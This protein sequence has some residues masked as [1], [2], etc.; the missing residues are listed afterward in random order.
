M[1]FQRYS[2]IENACHQKLLNCISLHGFSNETYVVQEK[3][4]G[5]NFSFWFDGTKFRQ[6]KRSSFVD[7]SFFDCAQIV[8]E[9][10]PKIRKAFEV[11]NLS[12]GDVLVIYGEM[13]GGYYNH[14]DVP[15]KSKAVQKGISYRPDK[16][17]YAFDLV[18][19]GRIMSVDVANSLFEICGIDHAVTL[20]EG[21][22][23]ECLEYPNEFVPAIPGRLGLPSIEG[24][25][26]E[27]VVIR[28]KIPLFLPSGDRVILKNKNSK[29]SE[30]NPKRI[31]K[32]GSVQ[33]CNPADIGEELRETFEEAQD[34]IT[35]NRLRNALSKIEVKDHKSFGPLLQEVYTDIIEELKKGDNF[36]NLTFEDQGLIAKLIKTEIS[37]F[38][39][40]RFVNILDGGF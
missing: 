20:F 27:G 36:E 11:L 18:V 13:Y 8:F 32:A 7:D 6:A 9:N 37:A 34:M 38:I 25:I 17:F 2:S 30:N 29:W 22:L 35:E 16:G 4:H 15:T 31:R 28:P 12:P 21:S 24:N 40:Q 10:E 26:C 3:I 19:N 39:R 5:A 33:V 14:P 1:K 23:Q